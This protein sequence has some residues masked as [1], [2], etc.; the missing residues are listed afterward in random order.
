M[1]HFCHAEKIE[2]NSDSGRKG[3]KRGYGGAYARI[4][5]NLLLAGVWSQ[6]VRFVLGAFGR[7][8][9]SVA[10]E[11]F[12]HLIQFIKK[13][14]KCY[15]SSAICKNIVRINCITLQHK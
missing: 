8:L 10:L 5:L 6:A 11:T 3:C 7:N 13:F 15:F 14:Y 2:I 9:A 1:R 12:S 4:W